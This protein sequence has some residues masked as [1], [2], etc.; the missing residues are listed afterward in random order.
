MIWAGA[1][2]AERLRG[3]LRN[4]GL[5]TAGRGCWREN[6]GCGDD[7]MCGEV[8]VKCE[9]KIGWKREGVE[10]GGG[11]TRCERGSSG[12]ETVKQG[13]GIDPSWGWRKIE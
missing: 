10:K 4:G 9:W 3:Y 13:R 5:G 11:V 2:E 12:P 1:C 7:G 8:S 6:G